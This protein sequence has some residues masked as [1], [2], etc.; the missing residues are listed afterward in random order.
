M[1]CSVEVVAYIKA[2]SPLFNGRTE[3]NNE[4]YI[5]KD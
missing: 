2:L 3:R 1:I 5:V 4:I